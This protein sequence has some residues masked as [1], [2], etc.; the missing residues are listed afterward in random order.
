MDNKNQIKEFEFSGILGT[1]IKDFINEKRAM[2]LKYNLQA[3]ILKRFDTF[4]QS[5]DFNDKV[6]SKD[7]VEKW[8][9]KV[10]MKHIKIKN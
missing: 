3:R 2:G 4:S 7:I 1:I 8:L 10:P 9:K 6:L 5:F